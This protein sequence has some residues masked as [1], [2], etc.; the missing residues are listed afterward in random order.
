MADISIRLRAASPGLIALP[1]L[2]PLGQ[3]PPEAADFRDL[4]VGP[5]RHLVRFVQADGVTY[6]LK[7]LPAR[8]A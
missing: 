6:A 1:W 8:V 4:D 7:E 3:W 5:S 2:E